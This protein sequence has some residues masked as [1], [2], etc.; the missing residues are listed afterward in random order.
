M[1]LI[2]I[3]LLN[4]LFISLT[5]INLPE[6][7]SHYAFIGYLNHSYLTNL[8]LYDAMQNITR[9]LKHPRKKCSINTCFLSVTL[10]I[11]SSPSFIYSV[12]NVYV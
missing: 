3:F 11:I 10:N 9:I 7:R 2:F 6:I 5:Y 12:N 1:I 8:F 4:V